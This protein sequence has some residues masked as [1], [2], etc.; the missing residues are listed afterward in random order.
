MKNDVGD[1]LENARRGVPFDRQNVQEQTARRH[2]EKDPIYS[3]EKRDELA[4]AFDRSLG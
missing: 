3:T 1:F 4:L 2:I